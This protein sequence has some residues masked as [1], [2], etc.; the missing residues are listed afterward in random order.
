VELMP[1]PSMRHPLCG[2]QTTGMRARW[3]DRRD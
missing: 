3:R 1:A 2:W